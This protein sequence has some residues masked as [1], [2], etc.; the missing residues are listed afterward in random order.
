MSGTTAGAPHPFAGVSAMNQRSIIVYIHFT[1]IQ[2]QVIC[3]NSVCDKALAHRVVTK[4]L[5]KAQADL[6]YVPG[7]AEGMDLISMTATW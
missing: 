4:Y 6:S 2:S 7:K 3:E 5:R 1:K